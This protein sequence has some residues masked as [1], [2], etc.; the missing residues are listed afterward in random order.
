M[1]PQVS[2]ATGARAVVARVAR[3]ADDLLH[4]HAMVLF[5]RSRVVGGLLLLAAATSPVALGHGLLGVAA[6]GLALR[7][8]GLA[9]RALREGP[10]GYNALFVG[11]FVANTFA[12]SPASIAL[13]VGAALVCVA[14][15]AALT[16]L[17]ARLAIPVL[18][19]PFVLVS[20]A[21][22]GIGP[23][24]GAP[25]ATHLLPLIEPIAPEPLSGVLRGFGALF[26]APE[27]AAGALVLGALILH[28]RIATTLATIAVAIGLGLT[29]A[30]GDFGASMQTPLLLN[31]A[32]TAIAVGGIWFV[33]SARS[34]ALAACG[35]LV[36]GALLLGLAGPLDRMGLPV[37]ILPF[38]ASLAVMLLS[39]RQRSR[40][41]APKAVDFEPGSP[42]ENLAY[43]QSRLA[44][45]GALRPDAFRL[46]FRGTWTCTQGVDGEHTH[47]GLWRHGFD[48]EVSGPD[49]LVY[50]DDGARL[51]DHH[52]FRLP[53]L[54]AADGIVAKVVN[55]V[56][57]NAVGG[58]DLARN[59]GNVVVLY[60]APGVYSLVA[61]LAK[62]SVKVAVGQRVLRGEVLGL[63]GSSGRSP[64]PHLHFQLQGTPE[65]GAPTLPC[66][67]TEAV[68]EGDDAGPELHR[69]HVPTVNE[70]LRNVEADAE[71]AACFALE[72]GV[73][74]EVTS[75]PGAV[76]H[77][78]SEV[79]LLGN[80]VLRSRELGARLYLARSGEVFTSLEVTGDT[81][82][83][84]H[85]LR[86]ALARVPF[87]A[88]PKL[89]WFDYLAARWSARGVLG[90]IARFAWDFVA[91]FAP[92]PGVEMAYRA[93][94]EGGS[95][96][97][98]GASRAT[99]RGAPIVRTRAELSPADGL[100]SLEVE[101]RG[102]TLTVRR[103]G[104]PLA[105]APS[106]KASAPDL[107]R[108]LEPVPSRPR[109]VASL[110][111]PPRGAVHAL[112]GARPAL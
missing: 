50:R 93:R 43:D 51:E 71:R 41:G 39:S 60:H 6:G 106:P 69:A 34:Y 79:D 57:D 21:L 96:V 66:T 4:L 2:E 36:S 31:G 72:P 88:D 52:C 24:A 18:A 68:L 104:L 8:L 15:T 22:L 107:V 73:V 109:E 14:L 99:R 67:F 55:D 42:E 95:V 76:E 38:S 45:E 82:S 53:V 100:L 94:R 29:H 112:A 9:P 65:L 80:L 91:P 111:S 1:A 11:L 84:L 103:R 64:R 46:P 16:S 13:T 59:W 89:V 27:E 25:P 62:S 86:A 83:S 30:L 61:H 35:T 98:V 5:S 70:Q 49:G 78:H 48:F 3:A 58:L 108:P 28:S 74:L 23:V 7:A 54:A 97:V 56:N 44:R 81:R 77:L 32:L 87:D 33:P 47:Q 26:F 10:Y 102:R 85:L 20:W 90:A 101:T 63:C 75:G 37:L 110:A 17:L 40:D 92:S 19:V 12:P 105:E